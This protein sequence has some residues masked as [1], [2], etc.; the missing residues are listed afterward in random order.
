MH[1]PSF[2]PAALQHRIACALGQSECDLVLRNARIF[3]VFTKAFVNHCDVA[4]VEGIIVNVGPYLAVRGK[5][6]IDLDNAVLVPGFI[7]AHVHIESSMLRPTEFARLILSKGTTT[8]VADPH[9][10]ANVCGLDG[11]RFMLKTP[12]STSALCCHRACL[13]RRLKPPAPR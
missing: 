1:Q 11:I 10:I 4:I 2:S 3:N 8:I 6:E 12:P 5:E 9:E 7:D 13:P